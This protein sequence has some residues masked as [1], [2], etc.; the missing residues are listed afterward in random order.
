MVEV[1]P[2]LVALGV[3]FRP[4]ILGESVLVVVDVLLGVFGMELEG[5]DAFIL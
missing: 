2:L 1:I 5:E 3:V 4:A